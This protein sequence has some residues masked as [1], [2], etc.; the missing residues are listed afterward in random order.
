MSVCFELK[1]KSLTIGMQSIRHDR[2]QQLILTVKVLKCSFIDTCILIY[3]I[4]R[5]EEYFE[6]MAIKSFMHPGYP[7]LDETLIFYSHG[8]SHGFSSV[9]FFDTP[10]VT[11]IFL[12]KVLQNFKKT[13]NC[14]CRPKEQNEPK[15]F[16]R[17]IQYRTRP[18]VP[19]SA[20]FRHCEI[21]FLANDPLFNLFDALR[22]NG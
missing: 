3:N 9:F 11:K 20:F 2:Y 6:K 15:G 21:F 7:H 12:P 16:P 14:T 4:N 1:L 5:S 8:Y 10:E 17:N 22:Q 18:K 13:P 19:F